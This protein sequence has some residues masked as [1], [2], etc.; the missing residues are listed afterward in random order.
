[1]LAAKAMGYYSR[2]MIGFGR[3]NDRGGF[4]PR[5]TLKKLRRKDPGISALPVRESRL[6]SV[7]YGFT[8]LRCFGHPHQRRASCLAWARGVAW[9]SNR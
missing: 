1:M 8:N 6:F 9:L 4:C 7:A 3:P 2:P 5:K